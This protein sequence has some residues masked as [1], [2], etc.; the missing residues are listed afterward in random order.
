MIKDLMLSYEI[1]T[2]AKKS[3][4]TIEQQYTYQ[5]HLHIITMNTSKLKI[6]SQHSGWL[7]LNCGHLKIFI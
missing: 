7:S 5:L 3:S 6:E 1:G 4:L 2:M